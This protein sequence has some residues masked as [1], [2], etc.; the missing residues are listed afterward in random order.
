M[1]RTK[2]RPRLTRI[3]ITGVAAAL[4]AV[5]AAPSAFGQQSNTPVEGEF[6][7]QR[8][9]PAPGPRNYITTRGARTD[10]EMA[11]SAGA[12]LNY[13]RLPFV[14]KSCA[15]PD[16]CDTPNPYQPSDVE[17]VQRL[18]TLDLLGSLTPVPWM[19]LGLKVPVTSMAG[20]G[21]TTGT[22]PPGL[23]AGEPR[24]GGI[25]KIGIG[26]ALLEGKFRFA[27]PQETFVPGLAIF[28]TGPLGHLTAK[29]TYIGDSTPSV[30]GRVILDILSGPLGA[31]V[32]IG[33]MYRGTSNVGFTK[34][35]AEMRYGLGLGYK[36]SDVVSAI[37]DGFG[38]NDFRSQN[39]L[40]ALEVDLGIRITPVSSPLSFIFGGGFPVID[41]V[42]VPQYRLFLGGAFTKEVVDSDKDGVPDDED[43]CPNERGP[44]DEDNPGC[45]PKDHDRATESE[46][47]NET[48]HTN[49]GDHTNESD[50]NTNENE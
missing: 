30:G 43:K 49:E 33:G 37:V 1:R 19:Q 7:V 42:G 27:G 35:G 40:G 44:H 8:F 24:P 47:M 26:D 15:T 17:V 46:R 31:A 45:P 34:V 16:N 4:C 50:S 41:A 5:V 6:T 29:D 14:L 23:P 22:D 38:A 13:S 48:E 39:P 9:D 2:L 25:S 12:I 20:Q 18:T 36:V 11:F 3:R 28:V 32:N 21:L 10:G